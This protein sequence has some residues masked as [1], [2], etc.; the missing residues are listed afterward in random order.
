MIAPGI[1]RISPDYNKKEPELQFFVLLFCHF[2]LQKRDGAI[3]A[4][5]VLRHIP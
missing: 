3:L 5:R 4:R 2:P 1:I